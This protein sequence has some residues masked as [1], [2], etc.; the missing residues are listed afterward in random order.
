MNR[1]SL[2]TLRELDSREMAVL[3]SVAV[4][5]ELE[6]STTPVPSKTYSKALADWKQEVVELV[7]ARDA[8]LATLKGPTKAP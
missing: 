3:R 5:Y 8:I 1:I 2:E 7:E 6:A 4:L